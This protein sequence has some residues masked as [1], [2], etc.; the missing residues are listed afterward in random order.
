MLPSD[1]DFS[2]AFLQA[3][4][5]LRLEADVLAKVKLRSGRIRPR[6]KRSNDVLRVRRALGILGEVT[7]FWIGSIHLALKKRHSKG[8]L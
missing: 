6:T 8:A 4:C 2:G 1:A 5:V 7:W 3:T